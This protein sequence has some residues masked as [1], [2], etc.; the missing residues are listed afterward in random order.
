MAELLPR[1][2]AAPAGHHRD[3]RDAAAGRGLSV[4]VLRQGD[5]GYFLGEHGIPGARD[6]D[7]NK[8]AAYEEAIRIPLLIRYPRLGRRGVTLD[9]PAL[10]I[11]LAPTLLEL[12]GVARPAGLQGT[13][14]APVLAGRT[15]GRR[16]GFLYEYFH[17]APYIVPT[18]VALRRGHYKLV[19]YPGQ[20]AWGEL[21]DLAADPGETR[22]LA[23]DA[24]SRAVLRMMSRALDAEMARVGYPAPR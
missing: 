24:A 19:R 14:L 18:L 23:H 20:P 10:N 22:N 16:L 11:D 4:R 17:E 1:L 15:G 2:R 9:G 6:E 21:F 8:R 12:A 3:L 5:N 7:G 13:S